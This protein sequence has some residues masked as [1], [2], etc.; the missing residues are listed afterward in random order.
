[1]TSGW[2]F[3]STLF[4]FFL[5]PLSEKH[6]SLVTFS[7]QQKSIPGGN[8]GRDVGLTTLPP[9][10]ANCLEFLRGLTLWITYG[11]SRPGQGELHLL[12]FAVLHPFLSHATCLKLTNVIRKPFSTSSFQLALGLPLVSLLY[13]LA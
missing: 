13:K 5:V 11:L 6:D 7:F 10:C 4:F 8:G 1:M 3:L 9:S 12:V 2:F